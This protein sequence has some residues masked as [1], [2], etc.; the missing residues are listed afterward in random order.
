MFRSIEEKVGLRRKLKSQCPC[1]YSFEIIGSSICEAISVV[2]SDVEGLHK[3]VLP[4]GITNDE[5]LQLLNQGNKPKIS[6]ST[7]PLQCT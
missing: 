7:R 5:A 2:R 6:A 4:F 3:D 1:G